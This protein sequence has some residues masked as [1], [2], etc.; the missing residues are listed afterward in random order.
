ML[1]SKTRASPR[2]EKG[3]VTVLRGR[4]RLT[5]MLAE[6]VIT[7]AGEAEA[8]AGVA[9]GPALPVLVGTGVVAGGPA[10]VG[11]GACGGEVKQALVIVIR[12]HR[13]GPHRRHPLAAATGLRTHLNG[14]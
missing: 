3:L 6:A 1:A 12:R 9:E 10:A 14:L 11:G 4:G 2:A 13:A 8:V 7:G 5:E